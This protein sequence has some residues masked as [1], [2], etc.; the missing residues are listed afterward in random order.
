MKLQWFRRQRRKVEWSD[1]LSILSSI[2]NSEHTIV[3]GSDSQPV[4]AGEVYVTVV[5]VLCPEVKEF[6]RCFFYSRHLCS[7]KSKSLYDR[8]LA[9]TLQTVEIANTIRD[10]VGEHANFELH[11]DLA[12]SEHGGTFKYTRSLTS[13]AKGYSFEN[14]C[15]KPDS[16]AASSIADKF[17]KSSR[18]LRYSVS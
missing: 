7:K 2:S 1:L 18:R 10:T 12:S 13:I 15:T 8:M 16:W 9:E 11:F 6:D 5:C 4:S 14:I 17:S 3:I